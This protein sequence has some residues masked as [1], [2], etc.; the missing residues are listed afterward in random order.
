MYGWRGRIGFIIAST[1][2]VAEMEVFRM[3]PEGVSAHFSRIPYSGAGTEEAQSKMLEALDN[4]ARVLAGSSE[5]AAVDVIGFMHG[6]GTLS[7]TSGFDTKLNERVSRLTGVPCVTMSSAIVQGLRKL[8]V[9]RVST[10][11]PL[12]ASSM[13]ERMKLF[14][15]AYGFEVVATKKLELETHYQVSSQSPES[16]YVFLRSLNHADC[17]A[18]VINNA[19]MRTL[20]V[21]EPLERDIGKPIVTGNQATMW[22]CLRAIGLKDRVSGGGRLFQ[23]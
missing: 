4:S 1:N 13:L 3:L 10:G 5:T 11:T 2:R 8:S 22:A 7:T 18:I 21:I 17:D 12:R 23:A 20:E 15:E 9:K 6:S 14:M 19:N 16:V